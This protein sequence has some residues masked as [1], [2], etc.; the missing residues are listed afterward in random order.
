MRGFDKFINSI[1]SFLRNYYL[2]SKMFYYNLMYD[3]IKRE[4]FS[5]EKIR[6][7]FLVLYES[8]W[9]SDEL[10]YMMMNHK[11]FDPYIISSPYPEHPLP[12]RKET[13][14]KVRKYCEKR[15]FPFI[16]GYNFG[17]GKWFDLKAFKPDIVFYTQPYNS[18]HPFF[19]IEKF[20]HHCLF[21]YIPYC[22]LMGKGV[23]SRNSLLYNI[24][25]KVF[26]SNEFELEISKRYSLAKGK[27]VVVSGFPLYDQLLS[28]IP[29][30]SIW[31]N[32]SNKCRRII[33]APHH[34]ILKD[35]HLNYSNFL[36][37]AELMLEFAKKYEDKIQ[38]AF[39]PHPVLKRKLYKYEG[40][41]VE[42]TDY[43]YNEWAT[44]KNT[45]LADGD[46]V[47]L[48]LTSD[49]MIHDSSSF[50]G[51]YLYTLKPVMYITKAD[52]LDHLEAFG[53]LCY[54]MHYKGY[55]MKDVKSFVDEVVIKGNDYMYNQ[56]KNFY[57]KYLMPPQ[58]QRVA[59]NMFN[60]FLN[61]ME[62]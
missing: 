39:K 6:V 45:I 50:S 27:N 17:N 57:V 56:R 38:I 47:N 33:W 21:S 18:G 13:Q 28:S 36:E 42:R 15:G 11:R 32:Q 1:H 60:E 10:F 19:K 4:V 23:G 46:Y 25:W 5:K 12:F 44:G 34:S 43:Y 30:Y 53:A 52:H 48:F 3:R 54:N 14:N 9:K 59:D 41:G 62:G 40:W 8:M 55:G 29:D 16:E 51:E 31:K 35:D 20:W 49:A 61:C 58:N 24:S 2:K 26:C 22:L 7:V 37:I